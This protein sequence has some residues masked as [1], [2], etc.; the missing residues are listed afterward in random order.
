VVEIRPGIFRRFFFSLLDIVNGLGGNDP[1]LGIDIINGELNSL[2]VMLREEPQVFP[3]DFH[4][5]PE[6]FI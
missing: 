2:S 5:C 3:S 6:T 1:L 4:V